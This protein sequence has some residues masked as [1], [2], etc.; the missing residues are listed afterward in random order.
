MT[1]PSPLFCVPS[2]D[3]EETEDLDGEE[4]EREYLSRF[5]QAG[6]EDRRRHECCVCGQGSGHVSISAAAEASDCRG[7]SRVVEEKDVDCE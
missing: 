5:E 6:R 4:S 7:R 1:P 2:K 3:W